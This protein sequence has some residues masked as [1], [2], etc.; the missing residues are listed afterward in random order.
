MKKILFTDYDNT[1]FR[2]SEEIKENIKYINE[3]ISKGNIFCVASGRS[4]SDIL[5]ELKKYNIPFH[6]LVLDNGANIYD[7]D[8]NLLYSYYMDD[9]V[10]KSIYDLICNNKYLI[11]KNIYSVDTKDSN[12]LN[13]CTKMNFVFNN[14]N[15]GYRLKE[16]VDNNYSG[17]VNSYL[18]LKSDRISLEIISCKTNKG[19]GVKLVS[20]LNNIDKD[21]VYVIG[22]NNNDIEMIKL[23]NGYS[24]NT[25]INELKI[26]SKKS[27]DGVYKLI[28]EIL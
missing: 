9:N 12:Y 6:Y 13:N 20:E 14:I 23:F 17:F 26:V 18:S 27:Y 4:Y 5:P 8:I 3:F 15:E 10:S 28:K 7:K 21:N 16:Y 25:A 19:N 22:D 1:L 24:V 11:I 2:N